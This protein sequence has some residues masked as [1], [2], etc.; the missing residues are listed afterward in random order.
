MNQ[1]DKKK[2]AGAQKRMLKQLESQNRKHKV[3]VSGVGADK[4]ITKVLD[5]RFIEAGKIGLREAVAIW[6]ADRVWRWK[7]IRLKRVEPRH[8][9]WGDAPY[10]MKIFMMKDCYRSEVYNRAE[11]LMEDSGLSVLKGGKK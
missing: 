1:K 3:T 8:A 5:D 7:E 9:E 11:E 6:F 10:G 4:V 2:Q